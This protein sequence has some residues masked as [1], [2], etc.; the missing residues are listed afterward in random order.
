MSETNRIAVEFDERRYLALQS[1]AERLGL[2]VEQVIT[3]ATS[4]W[5][6][7]MAENSALCTATRVLT[8]AN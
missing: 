8:A 5:I 4:A 3:R 7:E 1:E 2:D 6:C